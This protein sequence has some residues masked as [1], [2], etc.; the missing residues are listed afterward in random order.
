MKKSV[1]VLLGLLMTTAAWADSAQVVELD[2]KG[3][4][5]P[6]CV[7]S[8]EKNLGKLPGVEQAQVSL[9]RK[10]ARVIM[11]PGAK[12]DIE[13]IKKTVLDAGFTPESATVRAQDR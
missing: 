7:Y 10:Q 6:F 5:C 13:R 8:V 1:L 3:M 4:T 9:E 11:R 2:I 12:A